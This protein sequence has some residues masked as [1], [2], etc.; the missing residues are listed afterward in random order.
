MLP[1]VRERLVEL[2]PPDSLVLDVGCGAGELL[3]ALREAKRVQGYG[4]DISS[5]AVAETRQKGFEA[6]VSRLPA[7]PFQSDFFQAVVCTETLEHVTDVAGSLKEIARVLRSDGL[8][9]SSVP[10]GSVDLESAHVHRFTEPKLVD[11]LNHQFKDVN[12]E[13]HVNGAEITLVAF[14]TKR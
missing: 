6:Q 7:I 9:V 13:R 12:V 3:E 8:F 11:L 5:V 14:A 2:V 10:D 4:L 1:S